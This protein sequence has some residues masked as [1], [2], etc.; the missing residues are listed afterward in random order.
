MKFYAFLGLTLL[1][2]IDF[3]AQEFSIYFLAYD[4]PEAI[5][6]GAHFTDREGVV[7]LL[8]N[9]GT[10][11]DPNYRPNNGNV[12]P[13]RGFGHICI[14]VDNIQAACKRIADAGYPFQKKLEDGRMN[15]VAFALDPDGYWVEIVGRK[16]LEDTA[17]VETTDPGT[18]RMV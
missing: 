13:H 4:G 17:G 11:K 1:K 6:H 16:R 8:H 2:R 15:N 9:H 14:S 10:E 5:S 7:E 3:S 18:Y 12:E